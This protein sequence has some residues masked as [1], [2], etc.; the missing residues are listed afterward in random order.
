MADAFNEEV[1][2]TYKSH[3]CHDITYPNSDCSAC[4]EERKTLNQF[5]AVNHKLLREQLGKGLGHKEVE[6]YN[7]INR[8]N[9]YT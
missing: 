4:A 9:P 6:D 5:N 1:I 2:D 7:F 8:N 3:W